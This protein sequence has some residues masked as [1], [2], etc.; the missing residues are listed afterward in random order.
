AVHAVPG[1]PRQPL[2]PAVVVASA[3]RHACRAW[4]ARRER[5]C[6]DAFGPPLAPRVGMQRFLVLPFLALSI[7]ACG[8]PPEPG[9]DVVGS[10]RELPSDS[11]RPVDT[12]DVI[13]F[14]TDGT[15]K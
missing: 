6:G 15:W 10:W 1:L 2:R 12:R 4:Q 13:T 14:A 5:S 9:G 8:G 3:S 7:A 11:T